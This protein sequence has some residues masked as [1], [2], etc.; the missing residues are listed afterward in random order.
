MLTLRIDFANGGSGFHTA[1]TIQVSDNNCGFIL[2]GD[3]EERLVLCPGDVAYIMNSHGKTISVHSN[4]NTN[5]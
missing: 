3:W 4:T 1:K 2:D 5:K